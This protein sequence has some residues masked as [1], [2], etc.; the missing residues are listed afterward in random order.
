MDNNV[1]LEEEIFTRARHI[2]EADAREQFIREACGVD[3]FLAGRIRS[4][5]RV[6]TEE[7]TF[8]EFPVETIASIDDVYCDAETVGAV[9]GP[10]E[11][12][13]RIGAGGMGIVF[14]AQQTSP[15]RRQVALKIIRPGMDT[16]EAVR[17]FETERQTLAQLNHSCIT[18]LIDAGATATGRPW[19]VME[20][21]QGF[22]V[23]TFCRQKSLPVSDRLRLF[24]SICE[25]VQHAHENGVLHRDIKPS[26][27]LV[28]EVNGR[29]VP[30]V[31]DFGVARV[32]P[33][34]SDC[35]PDPALPHAKQSAVAG[36]PAYMSPEQTTLSDQD[37][38]VRCDVYSLGML[39]YELLT[40]ASPYS[41]TTWR[42]SDY[43]ETL[44]V[45]RE[46]TPPL[47]SDRRRM[48]NST[49]FREGDL[50][51]ITMKAIEKDRDRRYNSVADFAADVRRH[52]NNEPVVAGPPSRIY[53]LKKLIRRRK[54]RFAIASLTLGV[55]VLLGIVGIGGF[56]LNRQQS[57]FAEHGKLMQDQQHLITEHA[58]VIREHA[59]VSDIQAAFLAHERGEIQQAR[60]RLQ[61]YGTDHE[62]GSLIGF[63]GH[64][65]NRL[66]NHQARTLK[67]G[68]GK[69]FALA[70]S[71]DGQFLVSGTGSGHCNLRIWDVATSTLVH[72]IDYLSDVNSACFSADGT[73]LLTGDETRRIRVFDTRT[74]NE[75]TRLNGFQWPIGQIHLARDNRTVIATEIDWPSRKARTTFR[76]LQ[77]AAKS[78]TIEGQ[79]LLDVNELKGLVAFASDDG[80]LSLL[81]FPKLEL[82][83]RL[84]DRLLGTC[85]GR[86]SASGRFF[87]A[88]SVNNTSQLWDLSNVDKI[89][90]PTRNVHTAPVRDIAF[91]ADDRFIITVLAS[92]ILDARDVASGSVQMIDH[93]NLGQAWSIGVAA[94]NSTIAIG[95]ENGDIR[96]HDWA[97]VSSVRRSIILSRRPFQAIASDSECR[98][99][100]IIASD[101][102]SINVH[103]S[104]D[105]KILQSIT[106]PLDERFLS[107]AFSADDRELLVTN[108]VGELLGIN[109]ATSKTVARFAVYPGS[110]LD[111][112]VFRNGRLLAANSAT[113]PNGECG[114]WDLEAE[115]ELFRLPASVSEIDRFPYRIWQFLDNSS[116][117]V[118]GGSI[119][120]RWNFKSGKE[121]LPRV[122]TP[123]KMIFYAALL[124]DK[125]SALICCSDGTIV[126]WDFTK[127]QSAAV[128]EGHKSIPMRSAVSPNGRT[129]ATATLTGE[130]RLWHLATGQPLC[131][132]TGLTREAL[133]LWFSADGKRLFAAA[134]T[135]SGGSEVMVWD[136]RE[137]E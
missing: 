63:E 106:A 129:L 115:K 36:T 114:I 80:Y 46:V 88:G 104:D 118:G 31:I 112:V 35:K 41:G 49:R 111:P 96:I 120:T 33:P 30:K 7:T 70:F 113:S 99:L 74:W 66:C 56:S 62:G 77:D 47:P 107:I 137:R 100:A 108:A 4:L 43:Q 91:S 42:D 84:P 48:L 16:K 60:S 58:Q 134:K 135:A 82:V 102:M 55:L 75:I 61:R 22:P 13:E 92:A 109:L 72:S 1:Y 105:G 67:A 3:A 127:N 110:L 52:L 34:E 124:P 81:S 27:I 125:E 132:L 98:R 23:T 133:G 97:D 65:L 53:R 57:E 5:L 71:P 10:Y 79:R 119:L 85:C 50:D 64:F 19:F 9:I 2:A 130:V 126:L 87:A 8:L 14:L 117:L 29:Y 123:G 24:E 73:L 26:N 25:A 11:L 39:L 136:A 86:F 21:V 122:E 17:R 40:D 83:K 45:I 131:E 15:V 12:I 76:D 128:L 101:E 44:R 121:I 103:S 68:N 38:D 18:R 51:W 59:Y 6:L 78:T 89:S 32:T 93:Q 28:T 95:Y 20:L 94:N 54:A 37:L 90:Q 69:V 116:V